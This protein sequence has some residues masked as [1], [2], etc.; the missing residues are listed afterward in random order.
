M[1]QYC[2]NQSAA[3]FVKLKRLELVHNIGKSPLRAHVSRPNKPLV[4][5]PKRTLHALAQI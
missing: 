1:K 3:L 4:L 2:T 5:F